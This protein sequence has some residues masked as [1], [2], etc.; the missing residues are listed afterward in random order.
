MQNFIYQ[1][2]YTKFYLSTLL[3]KILFINSFMQNL[4]YKL[5]YAKFYLKIFLFFSSSKIKKKSDY[6]FMKEDN[7]NTNSDTNNND[8]N[9]NNDTNNNDWN[10]NNDTNNDWNTN[11]DTNNDWN[12]NTETNNDWNTN[13]ENSNWN[14]ITDPST[15]QT[16]N[17][18]TPSLQPTIECFLKSINLNTKKRFGGEKNFQFIGKILKEK[19]EEIIN[20]REIREIVKEK[21]VINNSKGKLN[22]DNSLNSTKSNASNSSEREAWESVVES[23]KFE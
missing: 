5:F 21:S 4:Y 20:K 7:W 17:N 22:V 19:I 16:S 1:L 18:L 9:T 23:S 3:C 11:S 8:W 13:T 6:L 14:N 12:T 2:F 10:T 15:F